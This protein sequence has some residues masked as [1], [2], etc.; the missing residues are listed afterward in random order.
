MPN[1]PPLPG[2]REP[3]PEADSPRD[4]ST[5]PPPKPPL[6]SAI[7]IE[8]FKG[9]GRTV[10][11]DLRPITLLFGR[12]SAGKSTI[13]HALCYAHEIL[14]R[15]NIDA[16]K[17]EPADAQVDLGGFRRFVHAHDLTR[18]VR[19]R[20]DVDL[21]QIA[22]PGPLWDSIVNSL[23]HKHQ[24]ADRR[25]H[26][27]KE[28]L[29]SG[30][31]TLQVNALDGAPRLASYEVGVNGSLVGRILGGHGPRRALDVNLSHPL[32]DPS[33]YAPPAPASTPPDRRAAPRDGW[34]LRTV[35]VH[36]ISSTL[37]DWEQTLDLSDLGLKGYG[38][39]ED[40]IGAVLSFL[41]VGVGSSVRDELGRL[42]YVGPLRALPP[43]TDAD[44]EVADPA[45][46]S[47]GSA[48]WH[49]L[50]NAGS[51]S[52]AS[53]PLWLAADHRPPTLLDAVNDWLARK[54]RLDVGYRLRRRSVVELET[55]APL[56]SAIRYAYPWLGSDNV[57]LRDR[58][59]SI[60]G[61]AA[62]SLR[63]DFNALD[64][65]TKGTAPSRLK[66]LF[67]AVAEAPLRSTLQILAVDSDLPV[68]I[69]D[70]GMGVSQLLPVV[71]AA[72]DP[73]RPGITAIEQPELH[74]H[75]GIQVELGD[76]FAQ[77]L[78]N[79]GVFL[80]ETHSEHLMLRL[81]RRIEET[82][83][84]ELPEGRPPVRPDQVAVVFIE[85]VD[86]EVRA[87]RLRIDETGEFRDRWPHG[88]FEERDDELF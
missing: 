38:V 44:P 50:R 22:V 41:L 39:E 8:N 57:L 35:D 45:R 53:L 28:Q 25:L 12:N 68:R 31:L 33:L 6:I 13:L 65:V 77:G 3:N 67:R 23:E 10:R 64:D 51:D 40:E 2:S 66:D 7:E 79:P 59:A 37:P 55:D 27:I 58:V 15:A 17:T 34:R 78:D 36:H 5:A 54:E 19:I 87:T 20:F 73:S 46:W 30:W 16:R 9:I 63:S 24:Q 82:H 71:V 1:D 83:S 47:D 72:L 32:L 69:A 21:R 52:A 42:R 80:I 18:T 75:P 81:L 29:T 4:F 86:G 48:A 61:M 43:A 62:G 85:Q 11:I 76:L 88:F 74:V 26:S 70:V 56:V 14:H 84:G 49:L 60:G